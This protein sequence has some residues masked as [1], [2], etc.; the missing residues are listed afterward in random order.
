LAALQ[1]ANSSAHIIAGVA[2][3]AI[4]GKIDVAHRQQESLEIF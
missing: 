4:I 1:F 3:I 2:L